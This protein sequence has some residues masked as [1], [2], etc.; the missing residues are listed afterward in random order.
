MAMAAWRATPS[1][2]RSCSGV[3]VWDLCHHTRKRTPMNFSFA[4][5]GATRHDLNPR[6]RIAG[7]AQRGSV[8]T[9]LE[10]TGALRSKASCTS[11]KPRR[12]RG[13]R[14]KGSDTQSG[15]FWLFLGGGGRGRGGGGGK[16]GR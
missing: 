3:K 4:I 8:G 16:G 1:I 2:S 14:L 9:S 5:M 13:I 15:R 6:R 11:G 10:Y 12:D 7:C